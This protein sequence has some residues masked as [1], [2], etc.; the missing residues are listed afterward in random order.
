MATTGTSRK[1]KDVDKIRRDFGISF[2]DLADEVTMA[3]TTLRRKIRTPG[4][5]TLDEAYDIAAVM[6]STPDSWNEEA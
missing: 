3:K 4:S 2:D 1:Y 6:G 5:F